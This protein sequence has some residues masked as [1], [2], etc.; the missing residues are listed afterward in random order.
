MNMSEAVA[1][2]LIE[3][4][5]EKEISFYE[6]AFLS[7]VPESTVRYMSRGDRSN[8]KLRNLKRVCDGLEVS[9]YDFFDTDYFRTLEPELES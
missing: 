8:P 9:L 3:L 4:C 6:L 5:K 2:R 1:H 7:G